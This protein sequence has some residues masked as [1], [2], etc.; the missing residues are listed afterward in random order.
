MQFNCLVN[1]LLFEK[2]L[3]LY[4]MTANETVLWLSMNRYFILPHCLQAS[5]ANIHHSTF[6][7]YIYFSIYIRVAFEFDRRVSIRFRTES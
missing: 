4:L 6:T 7:F 2:E 1:L 3:C 5:I